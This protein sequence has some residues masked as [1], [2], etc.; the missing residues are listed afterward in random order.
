MGW[1]KLDGVEDC[2]FE[3]GQERADILEENSPFDFFFPMPSL[4]T[5]SSAHLIRLPFVLS[6][7]RRRVG[8]VRRY[9]GS[10][11]VVVELLWDV[12]GAERVVVMVVVA[13]GAMV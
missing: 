11:W 9:V 12:V 7:R 6:A 3:G 13:L 1:G 4:S 8:C 5:T 2:G 10:R